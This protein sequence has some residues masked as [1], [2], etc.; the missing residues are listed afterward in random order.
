[1][2]LVPVLLEVAQ[3][4]TKDRHTFNFSRCMYVPFFRLLC[5]FNLLT[6]KQYL[7]IFST[8]INWRHFN[9]KPR[10]YISLL[11][12]KIFYLFQCWSHARMYMTYRS[13]WPL[14]KCR[15]YNISVLESSVGLQS[16]KLINSFDISGTFFNFYTLGGT[17]AKNR[18][19]KPVTK[20]SLPGLLELK[21]F[22]LVTFLRF[23]L[24]LSRWNI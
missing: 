11:T 22:A 4:V 6:R 17:P 19:G 15:P 9:C 13:K 1:M 12:R 2:K 10:P 14:I 8:I 21:S 5:T 20:I 24:Q 16:K 18:G 23:I 3:L 7:F